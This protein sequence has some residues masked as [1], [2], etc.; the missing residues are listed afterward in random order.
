MAR[1]RLLHARRAHSWEAP[2]LIQ[3]RILCFWFTLA[4]CYTE[5]SA[6]KEYLYHLKLGRTKVLEED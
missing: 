1:F 4:F 6:R 5:E 3:K 2:Y